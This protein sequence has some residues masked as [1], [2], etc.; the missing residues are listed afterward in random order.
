M[1]VM[2]KENGG[3]VI[4]KSCNIITR[5]CSSKL[6]GHWSKTEKSVAFFILFLCTAGSKLMKLA[7]SVDCMF[8][9]F[10]NRGLG[11]GLLY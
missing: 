6:L 10:R 3:L 1:M 11:G 2:E 4:I 8:V 7:L 9:L 5:R